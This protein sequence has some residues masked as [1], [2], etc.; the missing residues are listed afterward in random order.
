MKNSENYQ[1]HSESGDGEHN[2]DE[3]IEN[4]EDLDK[5]IPNKSK[6]RRGRKRIP[7]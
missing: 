1:S 4:E 5:T 7:N 3:S 6:K 2:E